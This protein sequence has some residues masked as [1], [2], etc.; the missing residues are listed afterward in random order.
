MDV[1]ARVVCCVLC[2]VVREGPGCCCEWVWVCKQS[3]P[4]RRK[5]TLGVPL[6]MLRAGLGVN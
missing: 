5:S 6:G 3:T 2:V 4:R 1:Y